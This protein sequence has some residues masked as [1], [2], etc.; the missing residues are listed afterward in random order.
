[1]MNSFGKWLGESNGKAMI[2]SVLEENVS[3][4]QARA[5]VTTYCLI[6]GI[7]VDTAE[8]DELISYLYEHYNSWLNNKDDFD[9]YMAK[10]LV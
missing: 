10:L 2:S 4:E 9:N 5:V 7:E 3:Q 8:W 1:M 6:F